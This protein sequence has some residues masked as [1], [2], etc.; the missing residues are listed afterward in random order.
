M[1]LASKTCSASHS[2][3]PNMVRRVTAQQVLL[4]LQDIS[5]D[6]LIMLFSF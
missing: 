3:G 2:L 6:C 1:F 5:V 4:W